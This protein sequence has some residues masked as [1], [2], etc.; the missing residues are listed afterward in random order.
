MI[1]EVTQYLRPNGRRATR[2]VVIPDDC[3]EQY[4]L[5]HSCGCILACEQLMNERAVQYIC[6]GNGDFA[7][8]ITASCNPKATIKALV[9]MVEAFDKEKF[10]KWNAQFKENNGT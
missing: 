5:I 9:K 7:S 10:E 3:Q 1:A 4:D 2:R 8:V 6:N